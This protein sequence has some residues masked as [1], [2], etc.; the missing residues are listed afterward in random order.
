MKWISII[1]TIITARI[2]NISI[3]TVNDKVEFN[4]VNNPNKE[5][6]K[7]IKSNMMLLFI[8]WYSPCVEPTKEIA[9]P[10][11]KIMLKSVFVISKS[12]VLKIEKIDIPKFETTK[13]DITIKGSN[14]NHK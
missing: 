9:V 13:K 2:K 12:N 7:I 1:D 6:I 3:N 11:R 4:I 8:A 14:K 10:I 5:A